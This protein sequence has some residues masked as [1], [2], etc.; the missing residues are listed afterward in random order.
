[1]AKRTAEGKTDWRRVDAFS[2]AQL[3]R[4]A[5]ADPDAAPIA[6]AA[7]MKQA[8]LVDPPAKTPVSIR[9]DDDVVAWFRKRGEGYQTRIHAVLRAYVDAQR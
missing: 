5:K 1:M 8:R 6:M 3:A 2:D 7:W 4:A 9:L